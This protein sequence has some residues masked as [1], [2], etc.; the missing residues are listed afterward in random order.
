MLWAFCLRFHFLNSLF[1]CKRQRNMPCWTPKDLDLYL[2]VGK[3][4][5]KFIDVE[6]QVQVGYWV[7]KNGLQDYKIYAI[8]I[9]MFNKDFLTNIQHPLGDNPW[10]VHM[11]NWSSRTWL[12]RQTDSLLGFVSQNKYVFKIAIGKKWPE[13]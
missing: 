9:C 12:L 7:G 8:M 5:M 10:P 11:K 2:K 1:S 13:N 3:K 4:E 6:Y